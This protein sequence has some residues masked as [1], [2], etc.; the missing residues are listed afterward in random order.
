MIKRK[1]DVV[2]VGAGIMSVTLAV[3]I[4]K[5]SPKTSIAI[6][7]RLGVAGYESSE[8][9]NNAG[10]G[11][12]GFCELNYD[13]EKAVKTF[14]SF[15]ISK[16]FWAYLVNQGEISASFLHH[17]PHVSYVDNEKDVLYLKKRHEEFSKH[18][19]FKDIEFSEDFFKLVEWIPVIVSGRPSPE[20]LGAATY[21]NRGY[22]VDFGKLTVEL[23]NLAK[24]LGVEFFYHTEVLD[25]YS[26]NGKRV[27][28]L[29]LK[30]VKRETTVVGR[31]VF[32]GA[33]GATL[34]LLE[35]TGAKGVKSYGGFPVKGKWLISKYDP[36]VERHFAKVYGKPASGS[37][38]M[39]VPHLDTRIIRGE[40][41]LI[42]GPFAG[43]STS[44]LKYGSWKDFFR[45]ITL[46]NVFTIAESGL[47]NLSLIVYLTKE[48]CRGK[49]G[50]FRL[51]KKFYP[52]L[53]NTGYWLEEEAGQRV[54]TIKRREGKAHIEFG[55]ELY[56]SPNKRLAALLGASPGASTS[57]YEMLRVLQSSHFYMPEFQEKIVEMIPGM[58]KGIS[59]EEF[60]RISEE[61]TRNI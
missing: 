55:T 59:D 30:E 10:T 50:K 58:K 2:L 24:S 6:I 57:V 35:K 40:K 14:R 60:L 19:F 32:I 12:S 43:F 9:F 51:L 48:V 49:K 39:S 16:Q 1:Y 28:D 42:F 37:P 17:V 20:K 8:A 29:R 23:A 4:K 44:F 3:L 25:I 46:R 53:K 36:A 27:W 52:R 15:E 54:Q 11:H 38:P 56:V 34:N 18:P 33:G 41:Y 5:I 61:Y 7:E 22:D 45:S 13:L 47:R 21:A 31:F 26:D